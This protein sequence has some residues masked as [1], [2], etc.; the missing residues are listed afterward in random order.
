MAKIKSNIE[1]VSVGKGDVID[2]TLSVMLS[3]G[4]FLVEDV[5]VIGKTTLARCMAE[6]LQCSFNWIS[7]IVGGGD[8]TALDNDDMSGM[9]AEW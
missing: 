8:F 4:H 6:S 7:G 9:F 1:R 3:G 5:P 2:L